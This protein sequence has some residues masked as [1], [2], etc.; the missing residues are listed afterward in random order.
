MGKESLKKKQQKNPENWF[1]VLHTWNQHNI[2]NQL[3]AN[4]LFK[5]ETNENKAIKRKSNDTVS[6]LAYLAFRQVAMYLLK[7]KIGI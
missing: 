1:T 5:K 6:F 4:N 2:V 7:S 3:Y